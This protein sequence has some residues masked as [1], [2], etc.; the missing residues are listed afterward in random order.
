M[1]NTQ[2]LGKNQSKPIFES[3]TVG[4][5]VP[6]NIQP[7]EVAE[8]ITN[9][10]EVL[11]PLPP[12]LTDEVPSVYKDNRGKYFIIGGAVLFFVVVLSA[13]SYFVLQ[14]RPGGL[15][16]TATKA[17]TLTYW[18]LWE[19]KATYDGLISEY[20]AK[21]PH[22]TIT[23]TKMSPDDYRAK[24][25]TRVKKGEGPDIF[26]FHNT[27][28][29]EIAEVVV[30]LPEEVYSKADFESTFYP[31]AQKDLKIKDKYYGLPL[32]IDGLVLIYNDNLLKQAGI[33]APPTEWICPET[34]PNDM[35][36]AV[37]KLTVKDS[38]GAI[39][40]S[41]LAAGTTGNVEHFSELFGLLLLLNGGDLK[42][43]D[44]DEGAGALQIYRKFAEDG[45]WNDSMPNSVAAF[46]QGKVA[47]I[48][49]PSWQV[50]AIRA[51]NPEIA[52]KVAPVP[53]GLNGKAVSL[54]DYWAEGVTKTSKNQ[55][56]AWKFLRFLTEK[57][58]Q[59]KIYELQSKTRSFG[60]AYS[61][62]DLAEK[63]V[64]HEFLGPVISQ[65]NIYSSLPLVSR[66]G[67]KGLNDEVIQYITNA[68]NS[69]ANQVD[70]R[71]A[72]G[73]AQQGI[74]QIFTKFKI[75]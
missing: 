44:S 49:A 5:D 32:Y 24:L 71:A 60:N 67:D 18:G 15:A 39:I 73:P 59:T 62:V 26:R 46:I 48:I 28:L 61:R 75:E 17:V 31:V 36:T 2:N 54:A 66:T 38:S 56:E 22:V 43:L 68:I 74:T 52:V 27:W 4:D 3:V 21:N 40:T 47:M 14:R 51:Q 41:G 8:G 13:V 42:K 63:L 11:N 55:V 19:E 65:G 7:E 45:Y 57:E 25:I 10:E 35:L 23:Y 64:S 72:L 50:H 12:D 69:A 70:Y 1:D 29:P 37:S 16:P 30:P 9:A 20:Q 34:C 53:K 6:Q 58:S 33:A